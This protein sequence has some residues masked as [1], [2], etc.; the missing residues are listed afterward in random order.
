M[1]FRS[2]SWISCWSP[3]ISVEVLSG[4]GFRRGPSQQRQKIAES[5]GH[6]A[7]VAIGDHAGGAV[8]LAQARLVGAEDQRHVGEHRQ[9]RAQRLVEQDLLGGIR[10][11]V[12]AAD[13]VA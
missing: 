12:G 6:D 11:M 2:N 4:A 13:D 7:F 8:T 10:N 1:P 5:F 3:R 9:R